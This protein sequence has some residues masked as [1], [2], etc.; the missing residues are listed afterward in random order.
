[1]AKGCDR[2]NMSR[3]LFFFLLICISGPAV[4]QRTANNAVTQ[5][6]DAFG[7]A[8]GN[9]RIGIYSSEE[10]RGFNPIEA[11]NARIE[12]LYFDQQG[13]PSNRL[14]DSSAVRVGY[15]A[16]GYAFP[17]PTGI[18]DLKLEKFDGKR[19]ISMDVETDADF[20]IN[21][22]IQFKLP[23]AG[24]RLGISF[25]QGFRSGRQPHSRSGD[26]QSQSVLLSWRPVPTSEV[27]VF[28]SRFSAAKLGASPIIFPATPA[29][30]KQIARKKYLGQPWARGKNSSINAGLI[31]KFSLGS[32]KLDAGLFRSERKDKRSFADLL[33]GV[34][35]AGTVAN[36]VIVADED[37]FQGSTSGE[38]RLTRVWTGETFRHSLAAT[39]RGRDQARGFGGQDREVLGGAHVIF[40]PSDQP[41]PAFVFGPNDLSSVRQFTVGL[42]YDVQWKN[43]GSLAVAVQKSDYRKQVDFANP[44]LAD[45]ITR[46]RPFLVS[47]TGSLQILPGL[48]AYGGYVGGLEES[49]VAPDIA[50]N[51]SEAPPALRTSQI[52]AGF[53]YAITPKLNLIAGVFEIQKP[54]FNVDATQRFRQL[55]TVRNRGVEVS[56][57]GT[58]AKGLTIIAGALIRDPQ[59]SGSDVTAGRI[60]ARPVGSYR[61]R[62]I[63][64]LDWRPQNQ[65]AW[66]FDLAF[67]AAGADTANIANTFTGTARETIGVGTRYRFEIGET[68][69]L[70][71][72]QVTNLLNDYGWR[73]SSS[74]GFTFSLPRAV[75]VSLAADI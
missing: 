36:R 71:R 65:E 33:T 18:V 38:I 20:N 46:D 25:G 39:L 69:L 54:Y 67:E 52:D 63:A 62:L 42:G 12:G 7:R 17:S 37:N 43:R 74:G 55:G 35:P 15:A 29:V 41:R 51:R 34:D 61:R 5:S 8:V 49:A 28:W 30:P 11:G 60:G 53:R 72:A 56:L 10:V 50:V 32:F 40:A 21:G 47:A 3:Q 2:K 4:A 6:D 66:S 27:T 59:I 70:L 16:R 64:N 75:L 48:S 58:L 22:S 14:I 9:E 31:A 68:K 13:M 57:A 73:V 1:M 26:F 44:A 24:E 19:V 45:A 23:L